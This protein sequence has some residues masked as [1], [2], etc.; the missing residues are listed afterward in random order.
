MTQEEWEAL[1]PEQKHMTQKEWEVLSPEQKRK[2]LYLRQKE[3]LGQF[4]E[5]NAI[6]MEQYSKSLADL[7]AKMGM[8]GVA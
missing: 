4:L 7:T 2:E 3:M 1:S 6:S 8:K 5:R